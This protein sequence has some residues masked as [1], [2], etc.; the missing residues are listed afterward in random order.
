[1]LPWGSHS[2]EAEEREEWVATA[3]MRRSC[4]V[5]TSEGTEPPLV[6]AALPQLRPAGRWS[7]PVRANA[8]WGYQP[9]TAPVFCH[10]NVT[11]YTQGLALLGL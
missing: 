11:S 9:R 5:L 3:Q 1:M 4:G 7:E 8:S 10:I 2:R 6:P